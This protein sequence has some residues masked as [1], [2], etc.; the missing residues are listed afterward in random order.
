MNY[1]KFTCFR[2]TLKVILGFMFKFKFN[3]VFRIANILNSLINKE[4]KMISSI[5]RKYLG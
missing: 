4:D 2:K 1:I 5:E 3:S